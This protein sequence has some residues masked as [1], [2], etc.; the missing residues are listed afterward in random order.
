MQEKAI[1]R[2][3]ILTELRALENEEFEEERARAQ[4][5]KEL[6]RRIEMRFILEEQKR[7]SIQKKKYQEEED[8]L[9]REETMKQLAERDKIEQLS[10][11]AKRRKKLEH[12][13]EIEE[14]LEQR[15]LQKAEEMA[16]LVQL[17][18]L[19]EHDEEMKQRMIEEERI[20]M[21]KE[22]AQALIGFLPKGI[23]RESDREHIPLPPKK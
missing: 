6:R 5:E 17:R 23:L 10:I 13:K 2:E 11:E 8:R 16:R 15:R 22:H 20:K 7:E 12:R 14:C 19:E 4:I 9:F 1:Q 18:V 21:L 3:N